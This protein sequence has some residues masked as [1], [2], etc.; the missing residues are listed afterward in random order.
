VYYAN[1]VQAEKYDAYL[2][3]LSTVKPI[4]VIWLDGYEYVRIYKIATLP[5]EI[6][7]ALGD[8]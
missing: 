5:P 6:F 1:Q 2:N 3:I 4:H 7:E 8:L